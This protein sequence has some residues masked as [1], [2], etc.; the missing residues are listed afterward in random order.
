[1]QWLNQT[2]ALDF[3]TETLYDGRRVRLLTMIDEGN[4]EGSKI[5]MGL[6]LLSRRVIRVL[7]ELV[8][9][10]GVR[11]PSAS[12][13]TQNFTRRLPLIDHGGA[14]LLGLRVPAPDDDDL[15]QIK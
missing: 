11:Q 15:V 9:V 7:D 3:M 1:M 5:A 2:W 6:S 10:H 12:T 14:W 13:T 8:A 4:R